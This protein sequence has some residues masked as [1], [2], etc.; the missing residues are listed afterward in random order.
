MLPCVTCRRVHGSEPGSGGHLAAALAAVHVLQH[1][2]AGG[3][4]RVAGGAGAAARVLN[5]Q[6]PEWMLPRVTCRRVHSSEPGSGGHPAAALA[7]GTCSPTR[8]RRRWSARR[9]RR[10]RCCVSPRTCAIASWPTRCAS[11]RPSPRCTTPYEPRLT[12]P[13]F[14]PTSAVS[15]GLCHVLV[16]SGLLIQPV[17]ITWHAY[18]TGAQG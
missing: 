12:R 3:G 10:W 7:A 17:V 11:A 6:N 18:P 13:P 1:A 4:G 9:W 2:R 15:S 5:Q 14:W 8:S 16:C